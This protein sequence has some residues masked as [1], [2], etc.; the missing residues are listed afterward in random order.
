MPELLT[1]RLR[2]RPYTK[3][4]ADEHLRVV[5]HPEFRRYERDAAYFEMDCVYYAIKRTDFR[6]DDAPYELRP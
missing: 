4:D 2:M 6:P 5:C 1:Q 3:E